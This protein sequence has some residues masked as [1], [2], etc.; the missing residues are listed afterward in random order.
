MPEQVPEPVKGQRSD[1]LLAM[2][3]DMS[4]DY[5]KR[6][7]GRRVSVL[8]EEEIPI[9][10]ETCMAGYTREYIRAA[11]SKTRLASLGLKAAPGQIVQGRLVG[12]LNEKTAEFEPEMEEIFH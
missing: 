6:F 9:N 7:L 12:M 1:I 2:E 8:W 3:A 11:V 10:G 4:Q 5:R